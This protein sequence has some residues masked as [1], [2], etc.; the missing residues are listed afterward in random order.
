MCAAAAGSTQ[1]RCVANDKTGRGAPALAYQTVWLGVPW[2][3]TAELASVSGCELALRYCLS[4]AE[5][6]RSPD[7]CDHDEPGSTGA[8]GYRQ[9]E[10]GRVQGWLH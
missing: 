4:L 9:R 5:E 10:N 7:R 8:E 3:V 6:I 1:D 2:N